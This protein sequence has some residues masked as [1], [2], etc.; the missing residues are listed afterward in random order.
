MSEHR[1]GTERALDEQHARMQAD[2]E[3]EMDAEDLRIVRIMRAVAIEEVQHVRSSMLTRHDVA[4]GVVDGMRKLLADEALI[5]EFWHQGLGHLTERGSENAARWIGRR[6]LL[7][8]A[9]V[10]LAAAVYLA[11]KLGTI[12]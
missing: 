3:R 12:K 1:S 7:S 10:A 8:V 6:V 2:A 4:E 9:G 11:A 5:R